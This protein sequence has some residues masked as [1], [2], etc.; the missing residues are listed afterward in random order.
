MIVITGRK[1]DVEKAR[2]RILKIQSELVSIISEELQIP[3]KYHQSFI[4][5]GGKLIQSIMEDCGGVQIKFPPSDSGSDKVVIRG[6]K[7]EV[8]KAKKTL[9]EMSNEKNLSGYTETIRSK[10]EHHRFLIGRSGLNIKKIRESTGARIIFPSDSEANNAKERDIITI[11]GREEA[12]KKARE[13]LETRIK[14]LDSNVEL[15]MHVDPKHHRHFVARRGEMLQEISQQYGGVTV[16]FP[17]SGV[18]SDRVV[19]KGAKECVEAA[20]QRIEEIVSD[21]EQ[22]IT[23]DCVI[24]QKH[25]RT[26]MGSKGSRVQEITKDFDVKIKF[27][28]KLVENAEPVA[29]HVNGQSPAP[30]AGSD[31]APKPCDIIRITGRQDRCEA[32]KAALI[33]LIPVVVEVP[34]PYDLHRFIIG[35][36]GKDVR[37]M[38]TTF[39]VNIKVPSAEQQC[40]IIQISGPP[41]KVEEARLALLERVAGL[42]KE[43]EDR[44]LK[45]FTLQVE[46]PPEYHSKVIGKKGAVIS[47]LRDDYNVNI[48]MPKPDDPNPSLIT[49]KGYEEKALQAKEAILKMVQELDDFVKQDLSIDHRIHSRLIGRRGRTIRQVMDQYKVEIR[50]PTEGGDPD[51]VSVIGPEKNVEE[52]LDYILNL[53]EE[54]MQD[55]D[56]DTSTQQYLRSS[57]QEGSHSKRAAGQT[58]FVVQGAPWEQQQS[59]HPAQQRQPVVAPNTQSNE[60]FPSFGDAGAGG[61]STPMWGPRR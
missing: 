44:A 28:E 32:A 21:L 33:A 46:V 12:V 31:G 55:I 43:R 17:R 5:A 20:K 9:L 13:Y 11:V 39:D 29:D 52:C 61:G 7:E 36:K 15:E 41:A 4:G 38:M 51:I 54:Y 14:D 59:N 58:G 19:L 10:P 18:D 50:F 6:P 23:L 8:E 60:E 1:D 49:I 26:I 2:D 3:A 22:Q 40:D 24:P 34:V 45:S 30:D 47:K 48:T 25:H 42:E 27:P 37:E 35:A 53:A 57:N 56:D 16:S